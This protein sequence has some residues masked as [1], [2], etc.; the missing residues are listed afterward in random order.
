[1]FSSSTRKNAAMLC[2]LTESVTHF[3]SQRTHIRHTTQGGLHGHGSRNEPLSKQHATLLA[4]KIVK[5]LLLEMS[6]FGDSFIRSFMCRWI[7]FSALKKKNSNSERSQKIF[8]VCVFYSVIGVLMPWKGS[9]VTFWLWAAR[10]IWAQRL[11]NT[12]S[13]LKHTFQD[14]HS[15]ISLIVSEDW[16]N[17]SPSGPLSPFTFR[18]RKTWVMKNI[19]RAALIHRGGRQH[20][21]GFSEDLRHALPFIK[22][23]RVQKGTVRELSVGSDHTHKQSKLTR[24]WCSTCHS[25]NTHRSIRG[26]SRSPFQTHTPAPTSSST[27]RK[28]AY[29]I[30]ISHSDRGNADLRSRRWGKCAVSAKRPLSKL[31]IWIP[32]AGLREDKRP[33]KALTLQF[34]SFL[35]HILILHYLERKHLKGWEHMRESKKWT[36][37]SGDLSSRHN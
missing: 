3:P 14:S 6:E 24:S 15:H 30:R 31:A 17:H 32:A 27:D 11:P 18:N 29:L 19:W 37:G 9:C 23:Q 10:H 35:T 7:F 2:V 4:L 20:R 22:R 21:Q 5:G 16:N 26:G 13:I 34:A 36:E 12:D 28:S 25:T 1:M 8:L 33:Q